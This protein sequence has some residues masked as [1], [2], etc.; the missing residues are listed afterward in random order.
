[1]LGATLV[2]VLIGLFIVALPRS[3]PSGSWTILPNGGSGLLMV[4]VVTLVLVGRI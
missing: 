2:L 1:M 3:G 4:M